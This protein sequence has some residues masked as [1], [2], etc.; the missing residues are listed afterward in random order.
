MAMAA[1]A[2]AWA[3]EDLRVQSERSH[4]GISTELEQLQSE[5]E[6]T[7][8][9]LALVAARFNYQITR[10]QLEALIGRAL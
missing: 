1:D 8:S 3:Q 5:F 10:A 4:G 7:Q 6:V 2:G 9:Q